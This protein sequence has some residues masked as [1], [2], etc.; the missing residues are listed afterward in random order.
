MF[1]PDRVHVAP[2][3]PDAL[4]LAVTLAEAGGG[5][6]TSDGLGGVGVLA[7]GSVTT[8]A[9]VRLLLGARPMKSA[10]SI[11]LSGELFV[12]LFAG[13]VARALSGRRAAGR[14]SSSAWSSWA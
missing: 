2:A 10:A 14:C 7:T 1:G 3:L 6:Q 8:A 9:E 11:V 13:L 5:E 12:V 4:D